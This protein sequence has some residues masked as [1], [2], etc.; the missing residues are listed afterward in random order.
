MVKGFVVSFKEFKKAVQT[1]KANPPSGGYKVYLS[2]DTRN[3]GIFAIEWDI[4]G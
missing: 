1:Y 2:N 4:A 3:N